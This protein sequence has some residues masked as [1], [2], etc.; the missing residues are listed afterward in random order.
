MERF[1]LFLKVLKKLGSYGLL[2]DLILIGGWSL[3]IY[4]EYFKN[5]VL[6]PLKRTLDIDF[7]IPNPTKIKHKVDVD[8]ILNELGFDTDY[9]MMNH[10]TRYV[11]PA[12]TIEFLM[13]QKGRGDIDVCK[14]MDLSITAVQLRYLSLLENNSIKVNYKGMMIQVPEP[15]AFT[16]HKYIIS[17]RRA[18]EKKAKKDLVTAKEMTDF[19]LTIEDQREKLKEIFNG[20]SKGW[21]KTIIKIVKE[22]HKGLYNFFSE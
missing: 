1:S 15:V 8:N 22:E 4:K 14:I 19:L 3:Y 10:L 13:D 21:R 11:H 9:N 5:N 2:E 6:L 17:K 7:L 20:I 18:K 16:L 12:L